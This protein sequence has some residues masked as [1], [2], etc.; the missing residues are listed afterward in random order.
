MACLAYNSFVDRD[1]HYLDLASTLDNQTLCI[2][3]PGCHF[4]LWFAMILIVVGSVDG[5]QSHTLL[6]Q[7]AD[8]GMTAY[9]ANK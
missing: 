3:I 7:Q 9:C 1:S 5:L 8:G 4:G 2:D 6:S